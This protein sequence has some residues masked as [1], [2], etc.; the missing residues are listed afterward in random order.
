MHKNLSRRNK[1]DAGWKIKAYLRALYVFNLILGLIFK[2]IFQPN[3]MQLTD[4]FLIILREDVI[5]EKGE[6]PLGSKQ[7]VNE[8]LF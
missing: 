4:I 8:M 1:A 6:C 5:G 2:E 3:T 7:T